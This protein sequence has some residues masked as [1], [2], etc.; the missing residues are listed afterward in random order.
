MSPGL[1]TEFLD[2]FSIS[3][4]IPELLVGLEID[5]LNIV[6]LSPEYLGWFLKDEGSFLD[7]ADRPRDMHDFSF[8]Y[9]LVQDSRTQLLC[10]L[11]HIDWAIPKIIVERLGRLGPLLTKSSRLGNTR[12]SRR[13]QGLF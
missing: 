4:V 3:P 12:C 8:F 1:L 11:R 9:L 2:R 5:R 7:G 6:C 10:K 13:S